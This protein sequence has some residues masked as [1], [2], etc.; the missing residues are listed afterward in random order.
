MST[1]LGP[2]AIDALRIAEANDLGDPDEYARRQVAA[3][4]RY[5]QKP[6]VRKLEEL[7]KRGYV[8]LDS[9]GYLAYRLTPKGKRALLEHLGDQSAAP[10]RILES[11]LV[12]MAQEAAA[13]YPEECCGFVLERNGEREIVP[14]TNIQTDLHRVNPVVFRED[15]CRAYTMAPDEVQRVVERCSEGWR[16]AIVYHSHVEHPPSF[17]QQDAEKAVVV[18]GHSTRPIFPGADWVVIGVTKE[19]TPDKPVNMAAAYRWN[20]AVGEFLPVRL[21]VA[22]GE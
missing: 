12:A 20:D 2:K 9:G 4:E 7:A 15:G 6:I 1:Y 10:C 18:N 16:V 21:E 17:S 5:G 19:E 13:A 3:F 22:R 14:V 11:E 8:E